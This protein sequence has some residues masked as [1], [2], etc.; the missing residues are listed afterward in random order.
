MTD[1]RPL[2]H[3]NFHHK[4]ENR[5]PE[6]IFVD[7]FN[8]FQAGAVGQAPGPNF[9][10]QPAKIQEKLKY[11]IIPTGPINKNTATD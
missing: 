1:F 6:I 8:V 11:I 3:S 9:A 5:S 2:M 4:V 10:R 7:L